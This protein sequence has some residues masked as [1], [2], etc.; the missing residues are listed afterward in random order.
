[1]NRHIKQNITR[2]R[3]A[4]GVRGHLKA[5]VRRPRLSVFRSNSN[6]Y[7]QV[8]DD[9]AS[10]TVA[11][12]R[13]SEIK[14]IKT[15]QPGARVERATELGKLIAERAIKA[16]ITSVVFDRGRYA[17]HGRVQALATGARQAG[18]KF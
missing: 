15:K 3:R 18:L 12:A 10:K 2:T 14:A 11:S 8:I 6:L 4:H 7:V 1:M 5:V 9:T 17:Y 16:G 13:L